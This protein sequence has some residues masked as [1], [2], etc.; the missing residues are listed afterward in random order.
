MI[1]SSGKSIK[2]YEL[3]DELGAGGFGAVYRAHQALLKRDVAIKVI[4]PEHA[5]KPD[6]VR[7]FE[8]EAEIVAR[9]EHPHIVPIYD[10]WRDPDGAYIV[11]RFIRGV[12]LRKYL[13]ENMFTEQ[14]VLPLLEQI[15][16]A[17]HFA[18]RH[19][20]VHR[21][22]KPENILLD[23][24]GNAYLVDFGIA[25]DLSRTPDPNTD[26]PMTFPYASP[27]QLMQ[28]SITTKSDLY[29]LGLLAYELLTGSLPDGL[30][31]A[32]QQIQVGEDLPAAST[33]SGDVL[34]VL[35][36]ATHLQP[37]ERPETVL[38]FIKAFQIA[39]N[40]S[41]EIVRSQ[42]GDP[43]DNT[44]VDLINPYKGLMAFQEYDSHDFFGRE[45]LVD[46]IISRLSQRDESNRFLAVVGPS[47]SG[48]SSV[49]KAGLLPQ[50]R[51]GGIQ[52]SS[53]W[54]IVEMYP[55][56][57]PFFE[58]EAAL[59]R[60]AV[61]PPQQLIE[62][63]M[64]ANGLQRAI[65][66]VLPVD[67]S[68]ELVLIIDQFEELFTLV[69]DDILRLHFIDC[70]L[71][72]IEDPRSRVR[73]VVT[74]RAD[75]YDKPMQYREFGE[76]LDKRKVSVFPMSDGE[77][78][79]AIAKP[80]EQVGA[81]FQTA[82]IESIISD[83]SDQP[84]MLPLLQYA[85]QQLFEARTG[86]TLT[87][88]AYQ[89]L[90][91][92]TGALAKQAD[93][94]YSQLTDSQQR[95][96]KQL[97]MRLVTLGEGTEDT[98][99]RVRQTELDSIP[100]MERV[101]EEFGRTRLLTF[102]RDPATRIPTVEVAHE[103]LI[104]SWDRFTSWVNSSREDLR[105]HRSL[106]S[107]TAE[108]ISNNRDSGFLSRDARLE[109][110]DEWA[111]QTSLTLS[112]EEEEFLNHSKRARDER[113]IAEIVRKA[114]E[115]KIARRAQNFQR[116]STVLLLLVILTVSAGMFAFTQTQTANSRILELTAIAPGATLGA[117]FSFW[118]ESLNSIEQANIVQ[119]GGPWIPM[120][121]IFDDF[122]MV[123]VPSGCFIMGT[124]NN[125]RNERPSHEQCIDES[126][127][128]DKYEVTNSQF[129]SVGCPR[130]SS[131][132]DQPRNC[133]LWADAHEFCKS[134]DM[135]LPT[136]VEWEYAAKGPYGFT[137]PWG[138]QWISD[139]SINRDNSRETQS[140]YDN[141]D[142]ASWVGAYHMIGNVWEW[143]SSQFD[144]Y[145]YIATDG[146]ETENRSEAYTIRGGSFDST[147]SSLR[148]TKRHKD[149][150]ND[151]FTIS[152]IGFR[153][154]KD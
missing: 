88:T 14:A 59:L 66:R 33:V 46:T 43:I 51:T 67:E 28:G 111:N 17:L 90:G 113:Q 1:E 107:A 23:A 109:H 30:S 60:V 50:L 123:F 100:E 116:A 4:L 56:S 13:Q 57:N 32:L 121:Q 7:R 85:L 126:Y 96:A 74:L 95:S 138:D 3:L 26:N 101:L 148:T 75:F 135:R 143:T 11:M 127:W 39:L 5:N 78:A 36:H 86:R 73:I 47:G 82:L 37:E 27:E 89:A 87:L 120:E 22:L 105:L 133:V 34:H 129:G 45:S 112:A 15:A 71:S 41:S 18:H 145:P 9:L 76:L 128:I 91:G 84:G 40:G 151:V 65:K 29:T 98:R 134:R 137:Y 94:V 77:L 25:K 130:T 114:H 12:N 54:F 42:I 83:I 55:G 19:L 52:G 103:A 124:D 2:G 125:H 58:L 61:N 97:F 80:A 115:A 119:N 141:V 139:Y 64:S 136:E 102:D 38:D 16:V 118:F 122:V 49:V 35:R 20:V 131:R 62:Q 117:N 79:D 92:V 150:P 70:L 81:V 6:F 68:V 21:D 144:N 10:Y 106:I 8:A 24:D 44:Y 93:D 48:K 108:W 142:S 104:R 132:A 69:R 31:H 63:L 154:A 53:N 147:I 140:V 152:S 99:R 153:C 72:C 146:R 149:A 110:F